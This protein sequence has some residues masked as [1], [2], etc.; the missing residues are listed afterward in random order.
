MLPIYNSLID[1]KLLSKDEELIKNN[2]LEN[3]T[4]LKELTEKIIDA[5]QNLGENEVR[6]ALLNKALFFKKIGDKEQ[7]LK[8][9]E[10]TESKTVALGQRI[11]I[12]FDIIRI[13]F[14]FNDLNL[15]KKMLKK[16]K[17]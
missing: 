14:G 13:G 6:E 17:F 7:A 16:Q 4:K 3:D 5:E 9:Y 15:I 12:L 2:T 8:S 11:D 1:L 10:K